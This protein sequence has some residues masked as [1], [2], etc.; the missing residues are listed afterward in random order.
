MH[1]EMSRAMKQI[2]KMGGFKGLAAAFGKG[3]LGGALGGMG[4]G[5]GGGAPALPGLGGGAMPANLQ[6]LMKKK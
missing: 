5:G 6:D 3:G 2:R 1:Q 4:M